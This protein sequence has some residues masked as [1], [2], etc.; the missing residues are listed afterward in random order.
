MQ[1]FQRSIILQA[2]KVTL[3]EKRANISVQIMYLRGMIIPAG[4]HEIKFSFEPS[5]YITGNRISLIS[6][7]LFILMTAG[8]IV[9][10]IRTKSKAE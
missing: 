5:S 7:L 9:V 3:T 8:Y 10:Q 4:E 1:S 2:G 6:S